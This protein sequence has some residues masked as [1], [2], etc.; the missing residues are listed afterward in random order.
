MTDVTPRWRT[1]SYTYGG[2]NCVEAAPLSGRVAVRDSKQPDGPW[3]TF[4]PA[5]WREFTRRLK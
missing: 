2:S 1:S 4:A 5:A 3:L